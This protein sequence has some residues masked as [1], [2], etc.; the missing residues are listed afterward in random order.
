MHEL[1]V[2]T[3]IMEKVVE[4]SNDNNA[5]K[6]KEIELEIG[7]LSGIDRASFSFVMECLKESYGFPDCNII[8]NY[9][10]HKFI[11]NNCGNMFTDRFIGS[12]CSEC[13]DGLLTVTGS[14][15][16]KIKSL[17]IE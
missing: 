1:S 13:N 4:I 8:I 17:L 5:E 3:S 14:Q 7:S 11:C 12:I 10:E 2:A 15:D 16:V 6:I 9:H